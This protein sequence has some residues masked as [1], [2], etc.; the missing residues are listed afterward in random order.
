M[1]EITALTN[2]QTTLDR[3]PH[4]NDPDTPVKTLLKLIRFVSQESCM[5]DGGLVPSSRLF[6]AAGKWLGFRPTG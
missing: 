6:R 5:V 2:R 3:L 1:A 4:H